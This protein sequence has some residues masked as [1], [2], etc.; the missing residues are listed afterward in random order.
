MAR[1]PSVLVCLLAATA[2]AF[3]P[4]SVNLQRP[5]SALQMA[6]DSGARDPVKVGV[7]GCGRIGI[8][9]LGAINKAPGVIPVLFG[10]RR[11]ECR[12]TRALHRARTNPNNEDEIVVHRSGDGTIQSN[13]DGAELPAEAEGA[14]GEQRR[15]RSEA[16]ALQQFDELLG[17]L[18]PDGSIGR[19]SPRE[20]ASAERAME[21][22]SEFQPNHHS[23]ERNNVRDEGERHM[24]CTLVTRKR[25]GKDRPD[26]SQ[27]STTRTAD[28]IGATTHVEG[29]RPPCTR[30]ADPIGA[31]IHAEGPRQPS[32][33]RKRQ[34]SNRPSERSTHSAPHLL[35][36][37]ETYWPVD[38]VSAIEEVIRT[39]SRRPEAP[40]FSFELSEQAAQKNFCVL[41]KHGMDLGRAIEAQK[42]S[43]LGPGSEF[44]EVAVLEG[45]FGRHPL[46]QRFKAILLRGS[47]WPLEELDFES[48]AKDLDQALAFGN[49]KGATEQPALL[50]Q[51]VEKDVVHG[52][53]L[54]L[55]LSKIKRLPGAIIAPMNIQKQN[56]ID[57]C[58]R[59]IEKDGLTHDQSFKWDVGSSVNARTNKDEL[60]PCRYG[61]CLMRII[62]RAVQLRRKFPGVPILASKI[63][64]KSAYRRCHISP[65]TSVQTVT[66]LPDL[67]L[68]IVA[69]R[70]TF[71][72]TAGPYEWGC[73]S[74]SICDLANEILRCDK[75]EPRALHAPRP[76]LVPPKL[77]LDEDVPYAEGR[78]LIVDIP[79]DPR[80]AADVFIDDTIGITVDMGDNALRLERAI[81]LAIHVAARPKHEDEP[82]PREDMAA[83]AKLIAEARCEETKTILGWLF[84]FRRL[85]VALPENK[86]VA[87]TTAINEILSR[88]TSTA[89]ELEVNVGRLVHTGMVIPHIKH[90]LSRLRELQFRAKKKRQ[91]K[92]DD[93]CTDDL[94]LMLVF[95]EKARRGI[96]MNLISYRKPTHVYRSDSCPHGLGGYSHEG[97]A[98]RIYL[99]EECLFRASN[100]LLEHLDLASIITPWID[101]LAGRLKAGDCS[102]SMTDSST[103]EGWARKTN[104]KE[105]DEDPIQA[106]IRIEVA[107]SHAAR[108]IQ[109]EIRD[110][111]QWFRGKD[112]VVPDHFEI[113]PLPNEISSWLTSLL[114]KLPTFR[115][116]DR[117]NPTKDED[118]TFEWQKK[119]EKE[120]TVTHM[121]SGDI[122]LCPVKQ[123][124][125]V[126]RRILG[127]PGATADTPVS[128]VWRYG[129]IEHITSKEVVDALRAAVVS[130]GEESLGIK[131]EDIGTHSI[132]SGAAMAMYLGQCP[133]YTIMMIGR[134]SSDAFLRYIRKQVEQFSH[135]VSK[136]MLERQ[137]EML[138]VTWLGEP[139]FPRLRFT[140]EPAKEFGVPKFTSDAMEVI[141]DP[142]VDAVWI[143]SPSQFHADQIKACAANGKHVFCEKPIA[144][145]LAETVEAINAC[146]EAGVKLMIGLQRRFDPNFT[147][148]EITIP[149]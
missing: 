122:L 23:S 30:P 12:G 145:D 115:D 148:D 69:L 66:Q 133:V 24:M 124:A 60:Q 63:D 46:W 142:E 13:I 26:I 143:C 92:L 19:T 97:F 8:V 35:P 83:L 53:A 64:Y 73:I 94:K 144:T 141:T 15:A 9:H 103:S 33:K 61:Y 50:R 25:P 132:R 135:N 6:A 71:G 86:Y 38:L 107:R 43:P 121:A 112:N 47:H 111:S 68:A 131:K 11:E 40:D 36:D 146:N 136:R 101:I 138:V 65:E 32:T 79:A 45:V 128:A 125:A 90:F 48:R 78:E 31:T 95:L 18:Q 44:R 49:H 114:L 1:F 52:Y 59:I 89:K 41:S 81:L 67:N 127:Y 105:D 147:A 106:T 14:A 22:E 5:T 113:V 28:P 129:R 4:T 139:V 104:F 55:P 117:A 39:D 62:N 56:S 37:A 42:H 10:G 72:G 3:A 119:D 93:K 75:W 140:L 84:D 102:L 34:L 20:S 126:V 74:E 85:T 118:V 21:S 58:G 82:I 134:W 29:P 108:L 123:W 70:Q 120:D 2:A 137:G 116:F 98:W 149:I 27:S 17:K 57:E 109:H 51:L 7:I 110:Y 130:V 76:E 100:N 77:L 96:S 91:I 80:G 16:R 54:V 87:W 88:G 99:P